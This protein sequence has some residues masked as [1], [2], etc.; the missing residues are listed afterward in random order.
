VIRRSYTPISKQASLDQIAE[1]TGQHPERAGVYAFLA[2]RM[3]ER[4]GLCYRTV[5]DRMVRAGANAGLSEAAARTS[6]YQGFGA[7]A[8]GYIEPPPELE[9]GG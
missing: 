3:M 6:V 8:A 9:G 1:W 4:D 5:F 7:A 2:A